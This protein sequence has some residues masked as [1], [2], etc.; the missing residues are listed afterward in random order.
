MR[1]GMTH[2]RGTAMLTCR[3][4]DD[5]TYAVAISN[6]EASALTRDC[7]PLRVSGDRVVWKWG[8]DR[9]RREIN[10]PDVAAVVGLVDDV[11]RSAIGRDHE[12]LD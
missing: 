10:L 12:R 2:G 8:G 7:N 6:E 11:Q 3:R 9:A 4:D 1:M 5:A